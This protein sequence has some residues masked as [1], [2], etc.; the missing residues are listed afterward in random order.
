MKFFG[1]PGYADRVAN[2]TDAS[3]PECA[4]PEKLAFYFEF[5]HSFVNLPC[6]TV[7]LTYIS[8]VSQSLT[9]K[10]VSEIGL[11]FPVFYQWR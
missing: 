3:H 4:Q 8:L 10:I 9:T 11:F 1:C 6:R 2:V 7:I 5:F